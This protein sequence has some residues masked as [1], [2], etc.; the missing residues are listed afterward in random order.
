MDLVSHSL[1]VA[2]FLVKFS[3]GYFHHCFT[4]RSRL[5]SLLKCWTKLHLAIS[6]HRHYHWQLLFV[7]YYYDWN[8]VVKHCWVCLSLHVR[9]CLARKWSPKT[10]SSH[11]KC[12]TIAAL[13]DSSYSLSFAFYCLSWHMGIWR[14]LAFKLT[15]YHLHFRPTIVCVYSHYYYYYFYCSHN[16]ESLFF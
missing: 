11:F 4:S 13:I 6:V 10:F 8:E 7:Y 1:D 15:D 14:S 2:L 16:L 12:S 3:H 9:D 5:S